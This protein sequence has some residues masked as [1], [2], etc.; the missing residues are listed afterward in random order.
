[1]VNRITNTPIDVRMY[2]GRSITVNRGV[3]RPCVRQ[4]NGTLWCVAADY[5]CIVNLYR[6]TDNGFSW[7]VAV[8]GIE[9]GGDMREAA[10]MNTD[11]FYGYIIIDERWRTLDVYMGEWES[12]GSDGFVTRVRYDLDDITATGTETEI[13]STSDNPAYGAFDVCH[14]HE[15]IFVL[16]SDTSGSDIK[17]TACSP[18]TTS[19]NASDATLATTAY[20]GLFSSCC[21]DDGNIY[22]AY[23]W[24]DGTDRKLS[25]VRLDSFDWA[26]DTPVLIETQGASP[27]IASDI[28]ICRDGLGTLLVTWF[29]EGDDT[30]HYA[31]SIDS[32]ANWD[33]NEL[34]RTSG[35]ATFTDATTSDVVGRTNSIGASK[36]GFL[37]TYCEDNSAGT[38]RCYI[39]QLTTSDS[40]A[41]Y[42]LQAEKEVATAKPWTTEDIVGVQFFVPTDTHLLDLSDPGHCRIAFTV[43]QGDST[44]MG[45]TVDT[46][47]GQELLWESAYPT[48]LAS[49]TGSH[50]L[51]TADSISLRVLV[52]IH[53]GPEANID[54]YA[55]G[56]TGGF[57]NRYLAAFKRIG[58]RF[59]VLR[60]QPD[61][62]N[63]LSDISA[64]GAPTE[65]NTLALLDPVTY[66]F[67][68]PALNRD[69]TLERV[70]QDI[71][72]VHFPPDFPLLR[73]FL[74]NKG[75]YLKRTVWLIEFDD[76]QY[77]ISQVI[78][79]FISNQIC[80]YEANCYV[81]GPSRDPFARTVLPSET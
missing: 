56:L 29:D 3:T 55:A 50:T 25:F 32:G 66:S 64:Y 8:E 52:D 69:T 80:F 13:L 45:D 78:P 6:S 12:I 38:P 79:R 60:Y 58:T 26:Y 43:G 33:V 1:M 77:E 5:S 34:T 51:D 4:D 71:R 68:S 2:N 67:P 21:D 10:S 54:Y 7:S 30:V 31:T 27:A 72:K 70:E 28:H 57:T 44:N 61:S 81:V 18:R 49:E 53:A 75:G 42:D 73:T 48:S 46:S 14:N 47:I 15:S 36:G 24:L 74:V 63:W 62:D 22:I 9:T 16:W 76:N 11:G 23:A 41:T 19:V 39:R 35:H 40:G 17:V 37:I 65:H 20:G 59:R